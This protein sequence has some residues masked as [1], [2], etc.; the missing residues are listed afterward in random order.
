M[1]LTDR[2]PGG[3]LFYVYL[4]LAGPP[5]V[6][7]ILRNLHD[8]SSIAYMHHL[9]RCYVFHFLHISFPCHFRVLLAE[10]FGFSAFQKIRQGVEIFDL[11]VSVMCA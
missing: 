4:M 10:Q 6:I 5:W 1:A 7:K 2:F 8:V 9:T 3:Y 11:Y